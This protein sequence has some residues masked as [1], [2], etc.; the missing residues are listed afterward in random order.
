MTEAL[1]VLMSIAL[2]IVALVVI[3]SRRHQPAWITGGTIAGFLTLAAGIVWASSIGADALWAT[4]IGAF[5][6]AVWGQFEWLWWRRG[7]R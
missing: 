6:V 5:G 1:T 7:G 4:M 2:P 3:G